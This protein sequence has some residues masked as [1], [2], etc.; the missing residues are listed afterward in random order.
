M[1][2]AACTLAKSVTLAGHDASHESVAPPRAL[3]RAGDTVV[4]TS[5]DPLCRAGTTNLLKIHKVE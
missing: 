5:G 3:L 2:S 1:F 4:I